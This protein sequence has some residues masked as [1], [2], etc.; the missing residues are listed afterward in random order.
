MV[1]QTRRPEGMAGDSGAGIC[2]GLAGGHVYLFVVYTN[3]CVR[4]LYSGIH[5]WIRVKR[6]PFTPNSPF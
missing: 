5:L 3:T 2:V 6:C 1:G 4:V